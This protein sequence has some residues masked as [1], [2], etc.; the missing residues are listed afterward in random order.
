MVS[1]PHFKMGSS[2]GYGTQVSCINGNTSLPA[3]LT[4]H[5]LP[6][7]TYTKVYLIRL[8]PSPQTEGT[9]LS[10]DGTCFPF[11]QLHSHRPFWI[12]TYLCDEVLDIQNIMSKACN[13]KRDSRRNYQLCHLTCAPLSMELTSLGV[14]F[15]VCKIGMN[16]LIEVLTGLPRWLNRL[17]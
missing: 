9:L 16:T 6:T 15:L 13:V 11:L 14:R 8:I 3:L 4:T 7:T 12:P 5:L 10:Q 17:G 2:G 1:H